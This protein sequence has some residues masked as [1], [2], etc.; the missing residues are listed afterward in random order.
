MDNANRFLEDSHDILYMVDK[1]LVDWL[2]ERNPTDF[3]KTTIAGDTF[4]NRYKQA[5]IKLDPFHDD[6]KTMALMHDAIKMT[7]KDEFD[8]DR[9]IYLNNHGKGHVANVIHKATDIL[10][11]SSCTLTPYEGYL[12]LMAI[13][14]HDV[15]I[16]F[17]RKD[18]N[19]NCRKLMGDI[20]N[21]IGV[22]EPEKK[23]IIRIS[24][25]H[26]GEI[27]DSK[28]TIALLTPID[29]LMGQK[30]RPTLLAAILRLAD[31]LADD[32]SRSSTA[33]ANLDS[34]PKCSALFHQYSLSLQPA[35]VNRGKVY[36]RYDISKIDLRRK[37]LKYAKSKSSKTRK[38]S[39]YL[40]DE[41][42]QR[43]WKMYNELIYC[44]RFF[45]PYM[46][47]NQ[48][49]VLIEISAFDEDLFHDDS[50]KIH[51]VLKENGYPGFESFDI[52]SF[53]PSLKKKTGGIMCKKFHES[54][55]ES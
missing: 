14:F 2:N 17:G 52:F 7:E 32:V 10:K 53:C 8:A 25:C 47:I 29:M 12:L 36:L 4:S 45:R 37:Y 49:E 39:T 43:T 48:I 30:I 50:E 24:A 42:Y 23:M 33:I 34:M 19:L 54:T 5:C 44:N 18:H 51:Y 38:I 27:L 28:D 11:A 20:G 46:D 16:I 15:G 1:H 22:D 6:V 55:K 41:V 3:P 31:E 35:I 9:L 40:I 13:Q 26:G 21:A